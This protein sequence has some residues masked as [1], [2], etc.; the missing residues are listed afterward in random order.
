MKNS[1][2]ILKSR[3]V[4]KKNIFFLLSALLEG[5]DEIR[6]LSMQL[7]DEILPPQTVTFF[8]LKM[9]MSR[10]Y[11]IWSR[12][13]YL[14]TFRQAASPGDSSI[15]RRDQHAQG[16]Q[17]AQRWAAIKNQLQQHLSVKSKISFC[18]ALNS[19]MTPLIIDT[20][21]LCCPHTN[22]VRSCRLFFQLYVELFF[23]FK[24]RNKRIFN[25]M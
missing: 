11:L 17:L 21:S 20:V 13:A 6:S 24:A 18:L 12:L 7:C 15:P 22:K 14:R 10:S 5:G 1:S 8:E 3:N 9:M 25:F 2:K 16:E 23:K 19:K 4:Q